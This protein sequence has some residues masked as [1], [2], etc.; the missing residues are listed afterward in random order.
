MADKPSILFLALIPEDYS[1]YLAKSYGMD[2]SFDMLPHKYSILALTAWLRK[3]G[4]EGNYRWINRIDDEQIGK[5]S[6]AISEL[7]PDAIG[8]SLVTEEM[9]SHYELVRKLKESHPDLP[10]IAGGCHVTALPEHTLTNFPLIDYI[11]IGEGEKTLT[12]LLKFISGKTGYNSADEINGLGFGNEDGSITLTGPREKFDDINVLPDPAYDLIYDPENPPDEKTAF[13]LVCSYGCYFFCTFCSVEHGNYRCIS[14]GKLVD[15]IERAVR[16]FG[17]EYF[18]IR[19][20][21]WPPTRKWLDEFCTEIEN[22]RL[23]IKFHFQTRA[24]TLEVEHLER[25]KKIGAVAIAVGVE[26][27]DP[28]ILKSI[29]KSITTNMARRA[30]AALNKVGIFSIA[31][32]IFGNRGETR[33]TIQASID[34]ANELNPSIAFFHVLYPLPG[35]EA[36]ESVPDDQKDWWMGKPLPTISE[37]SVSELDSLA[38]TAFINYPL[39]LAYF[40]QHVIGGKL[41]PEFKAIA[42]RVFFIHLRKN[43][44]GTAERSR[45]LR[46]IIRG[47]KSLIGRK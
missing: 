38:K 45:F 39:R 41:P 5:I 31:F 40:T 3:H 30:I 12:E 20:S 44:L 26:A 43:F 11:V 25:L 42:R 23:K 28:G 37:L 33:Q 6:H 10:V 34:L 47:V 2:R 7:K 4:C 32:F 16:N 27:G 14:S 21:F 19:D 17:T 36:F 22:R 46:S 8:L 29:K 9:V 15:R 24:G 18:A 13:P 35:A 1:P